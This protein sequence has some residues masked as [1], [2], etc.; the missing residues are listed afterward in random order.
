MVCKNF[1]HVQKLNAGVVRNSDVPVVVIFFPLENY[2]I[3]QEQKRK[4]MSYFF[5]TADG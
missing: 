3:K 2:E 4:V 1:K 5:N